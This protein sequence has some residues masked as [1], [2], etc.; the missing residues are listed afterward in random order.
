MGSRSCFFLTFLQSSRSSGGGAGPM[1]CLRGGGS[2]LPLYSCRSLPS[3]LPCRPPSPAEPGAEHTPPREPLLRP[4]CPA[5]PGGSGRSCHTAAPTA[6]G[7]RKGIRS[8]PAGIL[9]RGITNS[10][11]CG[12]RYGHCSSAASP[13]V[14]RLREGQGARGIAAAAPPRPGEGRKGRTEEKARSRSCSRLPAWDLVVSSWET[15]GQEIVRSSF[16]LWQLGR[17]GRG[18]LGDAKRE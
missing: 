6:P 7:R 9:P 13:P 2:S 15:L 8:R 1:L 12:G 4:V 18:C 16:S 5:G 14:A 3:P 10:P 17:R 11:P